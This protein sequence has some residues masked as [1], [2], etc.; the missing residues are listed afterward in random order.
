MSD[1]SRLGRLGRQGLPT[2]SRNPSRRL[3]IASWPSGLGP[4]GVLFVHIRGRR[5]LSIGVDG[6][7]LLPVPPPPVQ[8]RLG[9]HAAKLVVPS[10]V[11]LQ[12]VAE[13]GD[14]GAVDGEA[15]VEQLPVQLLVGPG[16]SAAV[17][18]V[19]LYLV[20]ELVGHVGADADDGRVP[21]L[22]AL[23]DGPGRYL[24]AMLGEED[25]LD[26][27]PWCFVSVELDNQVSMLFEVDTGASSGHFI[28]YLIKAVSTTSM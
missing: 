27:C 9:P 21:L 7:L 8:F 23:V 20:L 4:G 28:I 1:L 6:A 5:K 10:P 3:V 17:R 14:G 18:P 16:A 2:L 19:G 13:P 15:V 11:Q 12:F 24:A 22:E 25:L 26:P